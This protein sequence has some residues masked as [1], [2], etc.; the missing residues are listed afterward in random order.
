LFQRVLDRIDRQARTT[1]IMASTPW[2][3]VAFAAAAA[4]VLTAVTTYTVVERRDRR[5]IDDAQLAYNTDARA[6]LLQT[7]IADRDQTVDQLRRKLV[8]QQQLVDALGRP[9]TRVIDLAGAGQPRASARL[10]WSP[11]AGRSVLL[12]HDLAAPPVGRTYELWYITADQ[13]KVPATTFG[14]D[15]TGASVSVAPIPPGLAPL[16]VAAVTDE[17]IGGV[18]APTGTIQLA[19]K[20]Q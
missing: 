1:P 19:G 9:D 13:K 7:A 6:L 14:V 3:R 2:N 20:A 4:V 15:P 11:T 17:P 12:T 16:T 18:P 8:D 5:R 10:V